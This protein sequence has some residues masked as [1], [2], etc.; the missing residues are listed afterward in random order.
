[1]PAKPIGWTVCSLS[2]RSLLAHAHPGEDGPARW[3]ALRDAQLGLG[4]IGERENEV[5]HFEHEANAQDAAKRAGGCVI[6]L[7]AVAE[8]PRAPAACSGM[9]A[10]PLRLVDSHN[11][12]TTMRAKKRAEQAVADGVVTKA[13]ADELWARGYFEPHD[14]ELR[15]EA[16]GG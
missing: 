16:G 7:Y 1:M 6:G 14:N 4:N 8:A 5:V 15:A 11:F 13:Q 3:V 12:G 9:V 10:I 2:G